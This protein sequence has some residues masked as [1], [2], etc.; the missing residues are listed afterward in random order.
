[1]NRESNEEAKVKTFY[2]DGA[3][4]DPHGLNSG[5]AF[6]YSGRNIQRVR[7]S[8]GWTN[9]QAEYQALLAV[10]KYVTTESNV[11]IFTDSDLV[12]KQFNE[13]YAVRNRTLNELL[14]TARQLINEKTLAV[15]VRWV[16]REQNMAG[17]LLDRG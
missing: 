3:G 1:M 7:R 8:D 16:S 15:E 5:Y 10:L 12:C 14:T 9:N 2:V 17:S 11:L 4:A 13:K 6:V